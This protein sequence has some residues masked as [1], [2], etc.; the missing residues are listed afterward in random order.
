M[1]R[2]CRGAAPVALHGGVPGGQAG[3]GRGAAAVGSADA[4]KGAD[5]VGTNGVTANF[6]LFD[7]G[8]F[9]VLPLT[10]FCIPR[11]TRVYLFPQSVKINH[12]CSGPISVDPPFVRN[13]GY[14]QVLGAPPRHT[15]VLR[16]VQT[17][18]TFVGSTRSGSF[19]CKGRNPSRYR[20]LTRKF[21]PKDLSL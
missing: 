15:P 17:S 3:P 7:R 14:A 18:C 8:T 12:F 6:M 19:T 4:R 13:Q 9:G 16:T 20:Q 2:L 21:D 1:I 10:Y 5:G 11:S